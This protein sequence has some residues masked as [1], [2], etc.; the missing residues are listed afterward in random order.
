LFAG[1]NGFQGNEAL[2]AVAGIL[3]RPEEDAVSSINSFDDGSREAHGHHVVERER[4]ENTRGKDQT[5]RTVEECRT[6]PDQ[7]S[8]A[9]G[10]HRLAVCGGDFFRG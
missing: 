4:T 6:P 8:I 3:T 7:I 5:P 1:A 9:G 10:D 2:G